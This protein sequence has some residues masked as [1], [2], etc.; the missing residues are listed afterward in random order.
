MGEVLL[1]HS[2]P[3]SPESQDSFLCSLHV[4]GLRHSVRRKTPHPLSPLLYQEFWLLH[5]ITKS[6]FATYRHLREV[7]R[8]YEHEP[9]EKDIVSPGRL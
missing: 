1:S 6:R 2:P 8:G 3:H 7:C 5:R 9:G 4:F